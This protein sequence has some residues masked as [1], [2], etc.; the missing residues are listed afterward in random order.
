MIKGYTI[1]LLFNSYKN[2][3]TYIT[4]LRIIKDHSTRKIQNEWW[5]KRVPSYQMCNL[6]YGSRSWLT[7]H[8]VHY[9]TS[10][11]H[12]GATYGLSQPKV[13]KI[14]KNFKKLTPFF[15]KRI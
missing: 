1:L 9:N 8:V 7:K 13:K 6:I 12:S 10:I 15:N 3:K 2:D 11:L 5:G 14:C 4:K